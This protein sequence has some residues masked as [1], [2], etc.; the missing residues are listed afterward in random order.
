MAHHRRGLR[1]LLKDDA[2]LKAVE[3]DCASAGLDARR[4]AMLK[5]SVKLTEA[6]G[7]IQRADVDQLRAAG[8]SDTDILNIAE[9]VGYYAYVNR[10]AS[11]LGVALEEED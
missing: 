3:T 1:R 6:P 9:V 11:G 7:S 10:I 5:Y 4:L 8:F 2:L